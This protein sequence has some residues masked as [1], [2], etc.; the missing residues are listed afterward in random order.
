LKKAT[1]LFKKTGIGPPQDVFSKFKNISDIFD[2][3]ISTLS[4]GRSNQSSTKKLAITKI[5]NQN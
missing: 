1:E 2:T 4:S 3:Q 5:S